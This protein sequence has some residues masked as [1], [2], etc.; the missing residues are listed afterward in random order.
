MRKHTKKAQKDATWRTNIKQVNQCSCKLP[1]S[2]KV[3]LTGNSNKI[4]RSTFSEGFSDFGMHVIH[5][6]VS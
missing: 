3:P 5:I 6:H 1:E 2:A 4:G